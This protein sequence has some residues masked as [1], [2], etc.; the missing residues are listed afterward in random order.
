MKFLI[1]YIFAFLDPDP[2]SESGYG[3]TDLI[4]SVIDPD[5][6]HWIKGN[7][8]KSELPPSPH[9]V[10]RSHCF[11]ANLVLSTV[12]VF[13][14]LLLIRVL[15]RIPFIL[16]DPNPHQ[17]ENCVIRIQGIFKFLLLKSVCI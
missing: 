11:S 1:F 6:K 15:K 8:C 13:L 17:G 10:G 2:D 7:L 16:W 3:S 12:Q 9:G 14:A 5:P 4:E